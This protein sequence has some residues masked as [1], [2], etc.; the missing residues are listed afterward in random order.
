MKNLKTRLERLERAAQNNDA[1]AG[2][3]RDFHAA[4]CEAWDNGNCEPLVLAVMGGNGARTLHYI[5]K[6]YGESSG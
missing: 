2:R 5:E 1:A 4:F 3:Y 6:I